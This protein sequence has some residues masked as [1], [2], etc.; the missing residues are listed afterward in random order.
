MQACQAAPTRLVER[1]LQEGLGDLGVATLVLSKGGFVS[2]DGPVG[3]CTR[4]LFL[5]PTR[6]GVT[7]TP[8]GAT[9]PSGRIPLIL[10]SNCSKLPSVGGA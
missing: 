2:F 6:L 4:S 8:A 10:I 3:L 5:A 7:M 1:K 9:W